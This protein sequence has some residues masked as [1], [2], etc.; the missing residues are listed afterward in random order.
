MFGH[1]ITSQDGT[2]I[3]APLLARQEGPPIVFIH[4]FICSGLNWVRQFN[5]KQLLDNLYMIRGHGRSDKPASEGA[6]IFAK[7]A[8]DFQAVCTAF[9]VTKPIVISWSLCEIVVADVLSRYDASPL[10]V[11]G[12][13]FLNG[14]TWMSMSQEIQKPSQPAI[15]SSILSRD[16]TE[17]QKG[18]EAFMRD[19]VA[20][21]NSI[22]DED[23]RVW[24]E[25]AAG[26]AKN[27]AARKLSLSRTQDE[28]ALLSVADELPTLF[29]QGTED[30]LLDSKKHEQL[31]KKRFGANLDYRTLLGAG[32]APFYELLEVVNP[33]ILQF[34]QRLSYGVLY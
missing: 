21:G 27:A 19:F 23:K 20:P 26:M 10:P 30:A 8:E 17:F 4:G 18:L 31:M 13:A 5:D 15:I 12:H 32:N 16:T 3:L 24:V 1:L 14:I 9:N 7:H 34:A 25:S 11:V 2:R 29:I 6:Y 22:S 33:M 28:T